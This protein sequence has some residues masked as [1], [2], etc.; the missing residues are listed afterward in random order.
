MK[1][2]HWDEASQSWVIDGA[3][4]ASNI[5]L[6]NPSYVDSNGNSVTIDHGFTKIANKITKLEQ[7]LAWVYLNGAIGGGTGGGGEGDV[8]YTIAVAE[9]STVYTTKESI[10]LNVT[11]SSG[12]IKKAFTPFGALMYDLPQCEWFVKTIESWYWFDSNECRNYD[13]PQYNCLMQ[14]QVKKWMK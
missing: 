9:G 7:N 12:T 4:N 5:E 2:R 11:I 3:S 8:S 10:D 14:S 1:I 13:E 6:S